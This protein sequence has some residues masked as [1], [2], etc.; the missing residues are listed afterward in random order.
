MHV[1]LGRG[2]LA[3]DQGATTA[4]VM[5]PAEDP[6]LLVTQDTVSRLL[7]RHTLGL[8]GLV[9]L[10]GVKL[11]TGMVLAGICLVTALIDNDISQVFHGVDSDD[12]I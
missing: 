9:N 3:A 11:N 4:T 7:V 5:L 8:W 1:H 6:E 2:A 10:S 12:F